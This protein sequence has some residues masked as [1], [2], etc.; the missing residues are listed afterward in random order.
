MISLEDEIVTAIWP[1]RLLAIVAALS[2]RGIVPRPIAS[3][4][5]VV[6]QATSEWKDYIARQTLRRADR[7]SKD[8]YAI[9]GRIE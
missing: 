9:A 4:I 7:Q 1:R 8:L 5:V 2:P 3:L 6:A